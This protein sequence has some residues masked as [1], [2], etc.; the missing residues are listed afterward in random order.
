MWSLRAEAVGEPGD[1][2][3]VDSCVAE[4]HTCVGMRGFDRRRSR[5]LEVASAAYVRE[6]LNTQTFERRIDLALGARS[7]GELHLAVWD[8]DRGALRLW[9]ARTALRM[10]W[11]LDR[12]LGRLPDRITRM[13]I[14]L[15]AL[16]A[17]GSGATW[18]LGRSGSCDLTL[19]EHPTVSAT[20]LELTLR[21]GHWHL[22]DRASLNG[23][24]VGTKR[25]QFAPLDA[26]VPVRIGEL[27]VTWA[28]I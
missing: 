6:A 24:W 14:D 10:R 13:T 8:V 27:E 17:R 18:T 19:R 23:T 22:R 15:A 5:V 26:R 28:G 9:L 3:R 7:V 1:Q 2:P 25:V 20:H 12:V 11:N 4:T 16:P 21:D